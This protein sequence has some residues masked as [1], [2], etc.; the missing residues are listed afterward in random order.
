[1][2]RKATARQTLEI[3]EKGYYE[4]GKEQVEIGCREA[5]PHRM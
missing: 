1:M 4:I 5:V 2:D 3:M